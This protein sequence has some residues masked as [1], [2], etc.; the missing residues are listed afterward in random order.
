MALVHTKMGEFDTALTLFNQ[1]LGVCAYNCEFIR[2]ECSTSNVYQD[3]GDLEMERKDYRKA[4]NYYKLSLG[5]EPDKID[6]ESDI[7]IK[8][9]IK[10]A[11]QM[12]KWVELYSRMGGE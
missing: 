7:E 12:M 3:M 11:E 2:S 8:E 9:R 1:V 5:F 10:K 6:S 4:L